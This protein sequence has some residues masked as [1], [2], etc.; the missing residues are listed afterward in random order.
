[1]KEKV[2]KEVRESVRRVRSSEE[3]VVVAKKS[4]TDAEEQLA[5]QIFKFKNGESDNFNVCNSLSDFTE[6]QLSE[7][8]ALVD[9]YQAVINQVQVLGVTDEKLN[10]RV[11]NTLKTNPWFKNAFSKG[12]QKELEMRE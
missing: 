4:L 3:R 10:I 9:Y 1:M 2:Q 6:S 5:Q 11:Y 8:N 12:E 7:L